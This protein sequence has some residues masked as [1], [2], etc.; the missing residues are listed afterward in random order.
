MKIGL[1]LQVIQIHKFVE[2]DMA[3]VQSSPYL[4][5]GGSMPLSEFWELPIVPLSD[6]EVPMLLDNV[7]ICKGGLNR[8]EVVH[9][10][11]RLVYRL[12]FVKCV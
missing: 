4:V 5:Y 6:V 11:S 10:L 12:A 8:I 1:Q 3:L 7:A 2:M 9:I